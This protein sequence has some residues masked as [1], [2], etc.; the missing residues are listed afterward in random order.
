MKFD[1]DLFMEILSFLPVQTLLRFRCLSKACCSCI[2][3]PEF[4]NLHLK[5]TIKTDLNR[6]LVIH[7]LESKGSF[8]AI[9]LDSSRHIPLKL[10]ISES[11]QRHRSDLQFHGNVF[12]SCNGLLAM[13]NGESILLWNPATR[14]HKTLPKFWGHCYGDYEM[15]HGF[16]YDA[17]NDDYKLIVMIEHYME[18]NVRVMVYSLKGKLLTSVKDLLGYTIFGSYHDTEPL[19]VFV[20]GSLHWVVQRKGNIRDGVILAFDLG[21][22]KFFELPRPACMEDEYFFF[23]VQEI[24]GSL[25]LYKSWAVW[26]DEVWIMKEYGVMESWSFIKKF[27]YLAS[28]YHWFEYSEYHRPTPHDVRALC[29]LRKNTGDEVLLLLNRTGKYI[30]FYDFERGA[31]RKVV[32]FGS[33]HGYY[34]TISA[35]I[36]VRSLVPVE[37]ISGI[38]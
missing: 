24:G 4:I 22:E 26:V 23:H 27:E 32:I 18:N 25:A 19:G 6:S 20:G 2:D 10:Y 8:Y 36:C 11:N 33:S 5:H 31:I 34:C 21:D 17:L 7:G 1:Y 13:Y 28:K 3:N 9:D 29:C 30:C 14:K 35:N 16:G 15:L 38:A 12:G 37:F